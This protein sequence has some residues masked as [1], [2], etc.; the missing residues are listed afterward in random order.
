M[1]TCTK[2]QQ[3]KDLNEFY[4]A[5]GNHIRPQ[6]KICYN[7]KASENSKKYYSLNKEKH[8]YSVKK[9]L[10][11][12]PEKAKGRNLCQYWPG[13]NS[14][15]AY[16]KYKELLVMQD[17]KC[18]GCNKQQTELSKALVVDHDHSTGAV[19]GLLCDNCNKV[20]G[21]AND[22]KETLQNLIN[23]LAKESLPP[24]PTDKEIEDKLKEIEDE[25][26]SK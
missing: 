4:K 6:C 14:I 15:E 10:L 19:R 26:L 18:K 13:L 22:S 12:N 17:D 25:V 3:T 20:L 21:L 9:W 5:K 24:I 11:A 2:C 1:K 8:S 16:Y 23:Y 7:I